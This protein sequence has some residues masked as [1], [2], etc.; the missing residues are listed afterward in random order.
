LVFTQFREDFGPAALGA[1]FL[2]DGVV[3]AGQTCRDTVLARVGTF[4]YA[5]YFS[6]MAA[7][8]RS[9]DVARGRRRRWQQDTHLSQARLTGATVEVVEAMV[10]AAVVVVAAAVV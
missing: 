4:T 10:L 2:R 1:L 3:G 8:V 9:V 7:A 6:S 5:L